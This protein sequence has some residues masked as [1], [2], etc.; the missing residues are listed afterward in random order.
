MYHCIYKHTNMKRHIHLILFLSIVS[1]GACQKQSHIFPLFQE[2]EILMGS[3]PDSSLYLLESVQSPENLPVAEYA[4]WCLLI[5]QARDKN[6]V[7]H[8]SDS[9]I[10]VAEQKQLIKEMDL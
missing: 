4:S 7:E 1:L 9:L 10:D 8:T 3:R 5:T 6:H 2:A